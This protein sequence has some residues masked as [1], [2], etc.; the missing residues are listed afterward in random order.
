MNKNTHTQNSQNETDGLKTTNTSNV[1][2][3]D[4]TKK[5]FLE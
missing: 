3:I 5:S 1:V 4:Y 2:D